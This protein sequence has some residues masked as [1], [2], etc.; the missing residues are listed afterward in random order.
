MSSSICSGKVG[1]DCA[2]AADA[3]KAIALAARIRLRI[4]EPPVYAWWQGK[5]ASRPDRVST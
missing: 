3:A 4:N 2:C 5:N 1:D